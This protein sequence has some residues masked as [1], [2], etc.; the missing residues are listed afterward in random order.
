MAFNFDTCIGLLVIYLLVGLTVWWIQLQVLEAERKAREFKA[1]PK[2][3]F[4]PP[5]EINRSSKHLDSSR[6]S[7]VASSVSNT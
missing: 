1:N 5:K 6:A 2:P 7:S 4:Q 3:T